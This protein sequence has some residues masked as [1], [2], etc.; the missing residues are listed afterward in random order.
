[1]E[2][3]EIVFEKNDE[4]YS[5]NDKSEWF[6]YVDKGSVSVY[7]NHK[8]GEVVEETCY[9]GE[10]FG[11]DEY[12]ANK[13]HNQ[14]AVANG[15]TTV[16]LLNK[17]N[18]LEFVS[19]NPSLGPK[20]KD[21]LNSQQTCNDEIQDPML[22]C[23]PEG[24][25]DYL[26]A[27]DIE[28]PICK[29][30]FKVN[31]IRYA[32]LMLKRLQDDF[33]SVFY[34][35]DD[36]WYQIWRCPH[37]DYMNFHDKFFELGDKTESLLQV[38][39][40]RKKPSNVSHVK[41]NLRE[42]LDEYNEMIKYIDVYRM[43]PMT[44]ARIYQSIAWLLEDIEKDLEVDIQY[45]M[46]METLVDTWNNTTPFENDIELKLAYKVAI[47]HEKNGRLDEAIK[48]LYKASETRF[49]KKVLKKRVGDKLFDLREQYRESKEELKE[50]DLEE[51]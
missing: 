12:F 46:L 5:Y 38:S 42:V 28:C 21:L 40:P 1:M 43:K 47:I 6:Y 33:R 2:F 31:Q 13:D 26:F 24:H 22:K 36:L 8:F 41:H 9:S 35:F 30:K 51:V 44:K 3:K 37:C 29:V 25:K 19:F 27:K 39:L 45:D 34:N 7:S 49:A 18:L 14:K 32:K 20:V 11:F 23:F 16:F 17:T 50:K 4:I 48:F 10:I 15:H